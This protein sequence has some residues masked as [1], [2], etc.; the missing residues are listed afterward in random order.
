MS[1]DGDETIILSIAE[2]GT[3]LDLRLWDSSR[4]LVDSSLGLGTQESIEVSQAGDYFIEVFAVNGASN[5]VLTVGHAI[6]RNSSR[7]AQRLSDPIVP[8]ELVIRHAQHTQPSGLIPNS[9]TTE[10]IELEGGLLSR[11]KLVQLNQ[12]QMPKLPKG[13]R[14]TLD[15]TDHANLDGAE[16]HP[17]TLNQSA[18]R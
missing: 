16:S 2:A 10:R 14:M 4:V 1:L 6:T 7:P 17:A 11:Q 9:R 15:Q 18:C 3:D 13:C 8:G 12:V 5:Y